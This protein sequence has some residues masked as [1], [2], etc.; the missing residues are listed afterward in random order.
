MRG[1]NF[2]QRARKHSKTVK[3]K[4]ALAECQKMCSSFTVCSLSQWLRCYARL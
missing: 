2:G 1:K 4:K 3:H